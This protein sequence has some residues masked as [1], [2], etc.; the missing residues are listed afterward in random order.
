MA[1]IWPNV[2]ST[3]GEM[4]KAG[5]NE[6]A[7]SIGGAHGM[8][9]VA[10]SIICM[11]V[12][13]VRTF[14]DKKYETFKRA[15]IMI[16]VIWFAAMVF[17]TTR[18][19]RFVMFLSPPLGIS[20]GWAASD[21][22]SY[23]KNRNKILGII[24]GSMIL[25]ASGAVF[26]NNGYAAARSSFPL[27]D[28]TWYKVLNLIREKA[29][30]DAILNSWWDFGDWFKAVANHRVIFDGQS[31]G[32]PQAYWMAK[33]LLTDDE[34]KAISI[35]R[36]LNN[37]GNEAFDI[38]DRE[39]KNPLRSA[40]LLEGVMVIS[41]ER[42][43]STL[44]K[45]LPPLAVDEVMRMLFATP[46]TACFVVDNSMP[47]KIGA[48]S[49][50]GNWD[51]S[52]V[53]IAQNFDKQEK[54]Q[55]IEYLKSFG[56]DEQELQRF[57]QEVF[58]ISTKN[59]DEWLSRRLQFYSGVIDGHEKEGLVYFENGFAYNP[60]D[61]SLRSNNGQIPR[62]LFLQVGDNIIEQVYPNAN[63]GCSLLIYQ[64]QSGYKLIMLDRELGR[65]MLVRLYFIRGKGLKHFVPFIDAE[66]GNSYIR[67]FGIAW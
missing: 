9:P 11:A 43:Q 42:A 29:P 20:L 3:V 36:M 51:F 4:K 65:S 22:C 27:M 55:I 57:Y 49:Y 28:D 37:G 24:A 31:Q 63:I 52:K 66:E 50:L 53:Y 15:S 1:S 2:Y 5:I 67:V 64:T 14:F 62:S 18:G 41:P 48:I 60:K 59:L 34:N 32:T 26:I 44:L 40:L 46:S 47:F 45:F 54:A 38:I 21:L 58:L 61:G 8:W 12:L 23:L 10:I 13:F 17:A 39:I 7:R 35:L 6:M 56:R 19:V 30:K 25:A 16:L 33:A